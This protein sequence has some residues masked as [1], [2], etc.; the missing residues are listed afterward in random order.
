MLPTGRW[1]TRYSRSGIPF[2]GWEKPVPRIPD[3]LLNCVVYLY[4]SEA[5]AEEGERVG[6]SGFIIG[7]PL[8]NDYRDC[9]TAI[10]TN[11]HVIDHGNAI[12]RL[13][14]SDRGT[15]ILALDQQRWF[16][17]VNGD[18]LAVCL[19]Q[20]DAAHHKFMYV[21]EGSF[22]TRQVVEEYAI[23]PGDDCFA[24]GRYISRDGQQ[25]NTPTV[26]F[27]SIAQMPGEPITFP[28]GAM[29]EC[30]LVEARSIP[31]YSGAPV[32]VQIPQGSLAYRND[33]PDTMISVAESQGGGRRRAHLPVPVGPWL[34]GVD[35]C[36]LHD[37]DQVFN[38]HTGV[39]SNDW[40]IKSN[41]GMMGVVPAWRLQEMLED[42]EMKPAIKAVKDAIVA[43]RKRR[44]DPVSLDSASGGDPAAIAA[45][46]THREDFTRLLGA[47]AR[48]PA[49]ED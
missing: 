9:V 44:A 41:S 29:Q 7:I 42:A 11:K 37:R 18:D 28:D 20:M 27:G 5:A 10:V 6:G 35:C 8:A 1:V 2:Q 36:H 26:R 31:G 39:K 15:D 25:R 4:P 16:T 34:L 48:K 17:H 14:T 24:V 22:C 49:Q 32:F 40:Y 19:V 21:L 30:Y 45:N 43:K 13:N 3:R 12:A 33:V 38:V 47:A 46:P 23:G